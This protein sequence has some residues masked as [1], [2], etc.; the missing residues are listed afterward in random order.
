MKLT[1]HDIRL[2]HSLRENSRSSLAKISKDTGIPVSTLFDRLRKLE[3]SIITR[4]VTLLDFNKIGY[5]LRVHYTLSTKDKKYALEFLEEKR[6]INSLFRMTNGSDFHID[7]IF[8]DMK[9]MTDFKEELLQQNIDIVQ[10][11]FII[12]ELKREGF[13]HTT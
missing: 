12:E 6:S 1:K 11:L 4:H 2:M 5:G 10:E 9:E 7:C 13:I 8:R 3:N